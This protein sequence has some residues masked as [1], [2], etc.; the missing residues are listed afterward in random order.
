MKPYRLDDTDYNRLYPLATISEIRQEFIEHSHSDSQIRRRYEAV[1]LE[2]VDKGRRK[3]L[4]TILVKCPST[5]LIDDY[6]HEIL[7]HMSLM[8]LREFNRIWQKIE[9]HNRRQGYVC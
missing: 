7:E 2:P 1:G 8:K 9:T 6:E 5:E 3:L 4:K